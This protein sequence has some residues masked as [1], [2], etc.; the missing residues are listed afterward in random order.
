[1]KRKNR[2]SENLDKINQIFFYWV[3]GL[4]DCH[5]KKIYRYVELGGNDPSHSFNF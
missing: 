2:H 4:I 5:V 3:I 1:M